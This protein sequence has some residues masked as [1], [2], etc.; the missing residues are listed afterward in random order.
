M[1]APLERNLYL[2]KSDRSF[3]KC[4]RDFDTSLRYLSWGRRNF[5]EQP[6][7]VTCHDGWVCAMIEEGSPMLRAATVSRR[8]TPGTLALIGPDCAYGWKPSGA[9]TCRILL[10][11]WSGFTDPALISEPRS[12]CRIRMLDRAG[13]KSFRML[14]DVCRLEVLRSEPSAGYLDGCRMMFE[15]TIR[16]EVLLT[17]SS[18]RPVSELCGQA[19]AWMAGHLDSREP[20]ARMC[21]YLNVSQSTLYRRFMEE[22]GVSPLSRFHDLKMREAKRL[23][24]RQRLSVKET[25]FRL[26]YAHFNDLSRAYRKHFG[27][28]PK[29]RTLN[30]AHRI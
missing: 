20:V 29:G 5:D 6:I 3:W 1:R 24:S 14:H 13:R 2:P 9:G 22:V 28:C 30:S 18:R 4:G 16:R 11:M 27:E 15:E 25:A 10:W 17:G 7:P 19:E 23:L 8:L 12:A 21:D 26:G